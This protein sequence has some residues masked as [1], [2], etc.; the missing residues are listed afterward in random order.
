M[1]RFDRGRLRVTGDRLIV[2]A[3]ALFLGFNGGFYVATGTVPMY[4]H[5]PSAMMPAQNA[6]MPLDDVKG[7]IAPVRDN[8]YGEG[9]NCVD[10]AWDAMRRLSWQ[11]QKATIVRLTLDPPPS[12]AVLLVPT[13][14]AGWVFIE[15]QTGNQ[16]YPKVGGHYGL[17]LQRV[18]AID[19]MAVWF[20]PLDDYL[21]DYAHREGDNEG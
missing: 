20:M 9:Y 16:I 2:V 5:T 4:T 3:A 15:P 18:V 12:H 19:V 14:D 7:A 10:Y 8:T 1:R 6:T 21:N 17:G 13:G 11:G